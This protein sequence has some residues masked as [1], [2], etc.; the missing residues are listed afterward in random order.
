MR[1]SVFELRQQAD[2]AARVVGS[3]RAQP[4]WL[5]KLG[6][7][8]GLVALAA[9]GLLVLIPAIVIAGV[10]FVIGLVFAL[11]RG[12]IAAVTGGLGRGWRTVSRPGSD[13]EGRRNVRIRG[14]M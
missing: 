13:A 1:V 4:S 11:L 7:L 10:V 8:A 2:R 3:L 9:I 14:P 6:L 12:V 5:V